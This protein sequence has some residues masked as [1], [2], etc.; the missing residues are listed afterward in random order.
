MPAKSANRPWNSGMLVVPEAIHRVEVLV[1]RPRPV[2]EVGA[3]R[4]ELGLEVP[5]T[6][7]E[8]DPPVAQHV[9]ARDLLRQHDRIALREDDDA[10]REANASTCARRPT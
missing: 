7:T 9:E 8:R 3:D 4:T 2:L 6:D 1:G 10:R 5:D